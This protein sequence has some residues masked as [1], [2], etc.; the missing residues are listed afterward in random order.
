[1]SLSYKHMMGK[2]G[3]GTIPAKQG[4]IELDT[5][6]NPP[7]TASKYINMTMA[8]LSES[9][10]RKIV[11]EEMKTVLVRERLETMKP[12]GEHNG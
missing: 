3:G 2:A 5:R 11:S 6:F 9:D 1:M 8:H 12:K 7:K 10:V 4:S